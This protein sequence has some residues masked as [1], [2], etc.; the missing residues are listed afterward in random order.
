MGGCAWC[1]S[2]L[3][4]YGAMQDIFDWSQKK[5]GRS[6]WR[7]KRVLVRV[8]SVCGFVIDGL[9]LWVMKLMKLIWIVLFLGGGAMFMSGIAGPIVTGLMFLPFVADVCLSWLFPSKEQ[10]L[11][12]QG[13]CPFCGVDVRGVG[14]GEVYCPGCGEAL[15][16]GLR[17]YG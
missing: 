9:F 3:I 10:A 15:P 14:V 8:T 7:E 17:K 1:I 2:V 4:V 11:V 6:C 16:A 13:C 5:D 12:T